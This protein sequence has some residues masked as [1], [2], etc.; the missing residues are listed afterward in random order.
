MNILVTGSEGFIGRNLVS[1]VSKNS[2]VYTLDRKSSPNV[3]VKR[4]FI[5]DVAERESFDQIEVPIDVIYHFGSAS[6]IVSFRGRE[7]ELADQELKGF[8]NALE[9]A[10]RTGARKFI[11]P[12]TASV[13]LR[14]E[15][16]GKK[17][18]NPTN[19][20]GAVKFAEEQI[21]TFY[22][23]VL[24]TVGLRIFMAYGPGEDQKGGRA[25]PIFLFSKDIHESKSPLIYGDGTQTRDA[26]YIGDLVEVMD[27]LRDISVESGIFD[28]CTGIP[29][30]FNEII[31]AIKAV[32]GNSDIEATYVSRPKS[33]IEGVAG[34]PAF[35]R[36]LLGRNFTNLN[37]GIR[38][39]IEDLSCINQKE[40]NDI[41]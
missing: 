18:L 41:E 39:I 9:F 30:S 40:G 2:N 21:A 14:N 5:G 31:D 20:Y 22:S 32:T 11:F 35:T 4:H 3:Y 6:S 16:N 23:G 13:Y 27:K 38:N 33:Y 7:N 37:D 12:S 24:T 28:I 25:S 1:M 34:D 8:V 17:T 19:I 26:L 15:I 36:K 29:V 10:K